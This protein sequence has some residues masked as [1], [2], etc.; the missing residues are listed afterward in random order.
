M[1]AETSQVFPVGQSALSALETRMADDA[2]SVQILS[3]E[4]KGKSVLL[5]KL[6]SDLLKLRHFNFATNVEKSL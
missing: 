4:G 1:E 5:H 3:E 2:V 6:T